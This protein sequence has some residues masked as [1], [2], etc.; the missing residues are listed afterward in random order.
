MP[1]SSPVHSAIDLELAAYWTGTALEPADILAA[2][3]SRLPEYELPRFCVHLDAFPLTVNGKLDAKRLPAPAPEH[4]ADEPPR[5]GIET[6]LAGLWGEILALPIP[7]R[8]A[9]FFA[10]G[11]RSLAAN[12]LT[13]KATRALGRVVSLPGH[14]RRPHACS[15]RRATGR[16][17]P[18]AGGTHPCAGTRHSRASVA[19]AAPPVDH[20]PTG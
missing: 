10:L 15:P 5:P 11:G 6:R 16:H 8:H 9:D 20:R 19:H 13:L 18:H 14:L 1:G 7:G 12:R 4:V 17:P 2:L 3:A